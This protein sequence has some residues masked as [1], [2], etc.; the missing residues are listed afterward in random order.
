MA[1]NKALAQSAQGVLTLGDKLARIMNDSVRKSLKKLVAG[2]QQRVEN[3]TSNEEIK[4]QVE[5]NLKM[6]VLLEG[7]TEKTFAKNHQ[8]YMEHE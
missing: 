6:R 2:E 4:G 1:E 8:L 3:E 7:M 5:K